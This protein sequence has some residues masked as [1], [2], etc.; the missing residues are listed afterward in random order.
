[1]LCCV[2]VVVLKWV[3]HVVAVGQLVRV[4]KQWFSIV[5]PHTHTRAPQGYTLGL[6]AVSVQEGQAVADPTTKFRRT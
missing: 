4:G 6:A 3:V 2:F 1:M 5:F